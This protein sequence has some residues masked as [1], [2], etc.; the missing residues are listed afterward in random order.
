M[1]KLN[2]HSQHNN[3]KNSRDIYLE[4]V[5]NFRDLGGYPTADGRKVK[6]GQFFRSGALNGLTENDVVRL[7]NL[8]IKRICDLRRSIETKSKPNPRISGIDYIHLPVIP[9]NE[10]KEQVRQV[11][12]L[13]LHGEKIQLGEPGE[14]L[15]RLNRV[16]AHQTN[17]Y[18]QLLRMLF[19]EESVPLVIHCVAGKDRTGVCSSLILMTLGVPEEIVIEDFTYTN[20]YLEQLK[21]KILTKR[22]LEK[23]K[24]VNPQSIDALLEARPD[25]LKAFLKE[26]ADHYGTF[27]DYLSQNLGI[28]KQDRKDIQNRYLI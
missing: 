26:I 21:Q 10:D 6:W 20:N 23:T 4:G 28:S 22:F 5:V 16:I 14:M 13:S 12:E 24:D 8:G 19:E 7:Q 9:E 15:L 27:D 11:G 3:E 2:L 17:T 25:Y 1:S 18:S